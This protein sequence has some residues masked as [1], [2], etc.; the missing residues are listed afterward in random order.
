MSINLDLHS[1]IMEPYGSR[2]I[3]GNLPEIKTGRKFDV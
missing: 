3:D 2:K 1:Y